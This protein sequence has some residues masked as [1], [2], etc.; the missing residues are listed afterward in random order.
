MKHT[1]QSTSYFLT[2]TTFNSVEV[3]SFQSSPYF[4]LTTSWHNSNLNKNLGDPP[5]PQPPKHL[6]VKQEIF[7]VTAIFGRLR[8]MDPD[9]EAAFLFQMMTHSTTDW[10]L[11]VGEVAKANRVGPVG[12]L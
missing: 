11:V 8:D 7:S 6:K 9:D 4:T 1:V 2:M 3:D 5:L 12:K 10:L